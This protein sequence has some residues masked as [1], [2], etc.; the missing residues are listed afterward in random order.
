MTTSASLSLDITVLVKYE[1]QL[2]V[3]TSMVPNPYNVARAEANLTAFYTELAVGSRIRFDPYYMLRIP[4]ET[5]TLRIHEE[6]RVL[7]VATETRTLKIK[8]ITYD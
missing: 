2:T 5:R 6:T 1:A 4:A 7:V 3:T 8:D